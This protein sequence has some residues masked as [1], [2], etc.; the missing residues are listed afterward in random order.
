MKTSLVFMALL[1]APPLLMAES[2]YCGNRV[3]AAGTS[4]AE[5]EAACGEP[6]QVTKSSI[7]SGSAGLVRGSGGVVAGSAEEIQVE[8]WIYN[9]GPDRLMERI[10]IEN[11]VIVDMASLGYGYNEP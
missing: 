7:L 8:T 6:A 9:F 5:L 3:I 11:G 10:R 2:M 4:S 1:L